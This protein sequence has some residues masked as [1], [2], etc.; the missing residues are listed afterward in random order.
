[1]NPVITHK[2]NPVIIEVVANKAFEKIDK[3]G[4]KIGFRN[5][6]VKSDIISITIKDDN[7]NTINLK[8]SNDLKESL[9]N[10]SDLKI[11]A[12][13]TSNVLK[14]T[15]DKNFKLKIQAVIDYVKTINGLIKK[16][17]KDLIDL[18]FEANKDKYGNFNKTLTN[19]TL[20]AEIILKSPQDIEYLTPSTETT[21]GDNNGAEKDA[22]DLLGFLKAVVESRKKLNTDFKTF[23]SEVINKNS[24]KYKEAEYPQLNSMINRFRNGKVEFKRYKYYKDDSDNGTKITETYK[25]TEVKLTKYVGINPNNSEYKNVEKDSKKLIKLITQFTEEFIS[26]VTQILI[27]PVKKEGRKSRKLSKGGRRR[28]TRSNKF[29]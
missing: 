5:K 19:K 13:S 7:N 22:D 3:N 15:D 6:L 12:F 11:Q 29:A 26:Y 24:K 8:E 21:M 18:F 28:K 2:P 17:D 23:K 9:K 16:A 25:R 14:E 4:N 20:T 1:M 27:T 10:V